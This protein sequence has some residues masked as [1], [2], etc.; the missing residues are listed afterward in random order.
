MLIQNYRRNHLTVDL[1]SQQV[2]FTKPVRL[3]AAL[4]ERHF[5]SVLN[6]TDRLAG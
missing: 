5:T 2:E 1:L 4:E 6:A 3:R